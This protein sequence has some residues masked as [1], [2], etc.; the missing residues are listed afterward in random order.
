MTTETTRR[1][2]LKGS[3]AVVGLGIFGLPDSVLPVLAQSED[4]VPFTDIPENVR[5]ETPPDRRILDLRTI[6]GPFVAK[7]K[8][9]TT[10]HYGHPE[11]DPAAFRLKVTGLVNQT[12]ALSL[13]ELKKLRESRSTARTLWQRPMDGSTAQDRPRRRRSERERQG[14]RLLRRR[15]GTG[16]DRVAHTEVH[17]RT[18]LR[19]QPPPRKSTRDRA[20]GVAG[21]C[22][23]R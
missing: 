12:K 11:I 2:L 1:E 19:S 5:W 22:A 4:V 6:E 7:E 3:L 16:R 9:A 23:E 21:L 10:Q 18:K 15:Q 17:A 14:S 13:D 20:G 8:F